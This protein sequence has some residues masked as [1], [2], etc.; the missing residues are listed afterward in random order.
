[1]DKSFNFLGGDNE[2]PIKGHPKSMAG[3]RIK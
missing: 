2:L 1:M 3:L